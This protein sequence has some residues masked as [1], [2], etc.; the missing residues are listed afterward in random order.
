[1]AFPSQSPSSTFHHQV[2]HKT[3]ARLPSTEPLVIDFL[4]AYGLDDAAAKL[5]VLLTV[6][7]ERSKRSFL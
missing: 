7:L 4:C 1:M 5:G 6:G 2:S 3:V